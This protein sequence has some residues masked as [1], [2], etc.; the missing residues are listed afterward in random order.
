[1][2]KLPVLDAINPPSV[3]N[4]QGHLLRYCPRDSSLDLYR[5]FGTR[6]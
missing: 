2:L 5:I 6:V 4:S 3:P 1:M